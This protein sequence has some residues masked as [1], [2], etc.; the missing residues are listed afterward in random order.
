MDRDRTSALR[1]A[2]SAA[3]PL[4][5][6]EQLIGH[7]E[8][9]DNVDEDG[10]SLVHQIVNRVTTNGSI[11]LVRS[12]RHRPLLDV[13]IEAGAIPDRPDAK[14]LTPLHTAARCGDSELC[15]SLLRAG[16]RREIGA[17]ETLG[18]PL[19][20]ALFY[21]KTKCAQL[22]R[23]EPPSIREAAGLGDTAALEAALPADGP[24][25]MSARRRCRFYR[26][27][28]IFP[29][30]DRRFDRDEIL[31]EALTWAAR[32]GQLA[33]VELLLSMR[34]SVDANPFRGTALLW[35]TYAG[36][37]DV[38]RMLVDAGANPSLPHD[39]GATQHGRQATA[40]HLAAQHGDLRTV[41]LLVEL[42]ADPTVRDG[43]WGGTPAGW[44]QH[45][46]QDDVVA[47]L[48]ALAR[49]S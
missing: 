17:D 15:E 40:L 22:V 25:H 39:F 48:D 42:G 14:G 12:E 7:P 31:A 29:L 16:A 35:A 47:W 10:R 19:H 37:H 41:K 5:L 46:G 4:A 38:I 26:P 13:A 32:N 34:V 9:V 6:R 3:D 33:A 23:L 21:A 1:E 43:Q 27:S 49:P 18:A 30:W 20:H 44:A 24:V 45:A 36:Q 8:L 28:P 2:I 11:P